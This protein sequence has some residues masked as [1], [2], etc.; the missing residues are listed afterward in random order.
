MEDYLAKTRK[1]EAWKKEKRENILARS[2]VVADRKPRYSLRTASANR[3]SVTSRRA[4]GA[5]RVY[6]SHFAV[7]GSFSELQ[8]QVEAEVLAD[9]HVQADNIDILMNSIQMTEEDGVKLAQSLKLNP[10][11]L[12]YSGLDMMVPTSRY[13]VKM[14]HQLLYYVNK[15]VDFLCGTLF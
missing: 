13:T 2:T 7:D 10:G 9:M 6:R 14:V 15:L 3:P 5:G 1:L 4:P 8:A 11:N 12:E